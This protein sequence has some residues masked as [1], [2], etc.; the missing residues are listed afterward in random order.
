LINDPLIDQRMMQKRYLL[1][2]AITVPNK[3]SGELLK[4]FGSLSFNSKWSTIME[5]AN[6]N[7][8]S[9]SSS[10]S[11]SSTFASDRSPPP[12]STQMFIDPITAHEFLSQ[13]PIKTFHEIPLDTLKVSWTLSLGV[14]VLIRT[15]TN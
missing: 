5:L 6:Q 9:H 2:K 3:Q 4:L 8:I 13:A 11:F 15:S 12:P 14:S 1:R 7:V 10:S